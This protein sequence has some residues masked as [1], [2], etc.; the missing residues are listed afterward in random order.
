M[1][2]AQLLIFP[3]TPIS[4]PH[5]SVQRHKLR[6]EGEIRQ[7]IEDSKTQ[8]KQLSAGLEADSAKRSLGVN[9]QVLKSQNSSNSDKTA[10][11]DIIRHS[12]MLVE[13][14][15]SDGE[16]AW[17]FEPAIGVHLRGHGFETTEPLMR[18]CLDDAP[19]PI[20]PSIKVIVRCRRED[21]DIIDLHPKDEQTFKKDDEIARRRKTELAEQ[22]I[23]DALIEEGLEHGD[24]R[25]DFSYVVVADVISTD[26]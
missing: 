6:I 4:I 8:D 12:G 7:D 17:I 25:E 10:A 21:L 13:H 16:H 22:M 9:F 11:W 23:K 2:K 18:A 24:M 20:P 26:E 19:P 14:R 5:A 15:K 3:E 1:K